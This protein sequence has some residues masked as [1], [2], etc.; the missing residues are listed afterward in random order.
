MLDQRQDKQLQISWI[1]RI[2]TTELQLQT[3]FLGYKE[4]FEHLQDLVSSSTYFEC[5]STS[6]S[7]LKLPSTSET[8]NIMK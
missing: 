4:W 1:Y 7:E 8:S 2:I 3:Y 6:P 5:N